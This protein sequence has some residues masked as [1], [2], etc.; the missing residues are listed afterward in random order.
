M[1]KQTIQIFFSS[2]FIASILLSVSFQAT[3]QEVEDEREFDYEEDSDTGPARWGEIHPEWSTCKTGT[4]QSPIDML[5]DRVQEETYLG[6]LKRDYRPSNA[7]LVNRGHDMSLKW[8]GG[9]GHIEINGTQYVLKQ[10]HWHTPSEHTIN[11]E[12]FDL[13]F[14]MVHESESKKIAVIG[15]MYNIGQ[16]D[17]FLSEISEHLAA[18]VDSEEE[19]RF[20]GI[21]DPKQIKIGSRR[22]YRYIGSLTIPPC[23]QN[24]VWTIVRKVRTV[25]EE[26]VK[27][28]RDA[29]Q[30]E[31][32]T[33]A[34]PIQPINTRPVK[35]YLTQENED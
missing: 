35:L 1:E 20:V 21:V 33:N 13:E 29:V 31:H 10:C 27:L 22:Y 14:H 12:R 34:R 16:P 6:K 9:A 17:S 24:V 2:V 3:C 15:I 30:D 4:M 26:Q 28:L 32:D 25:S 18:I 19:K 5:N 23:S 8:D 11:G 7:T